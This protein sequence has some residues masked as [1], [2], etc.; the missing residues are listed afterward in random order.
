MIFIINTFFGASIRIII[1]QSVKRFVAPRVKMCERFLKV[2][3]HKKPVLCTVTKTLKGS[4]TGK[5]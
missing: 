5:F 3:I 1:D 2:N 4:K